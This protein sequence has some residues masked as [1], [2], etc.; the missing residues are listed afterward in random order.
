[1]LEVSA[2][3]LHFKGPATAKLPDWLGSTWRGAMGHALKQTECHCRVS[4]KTSQ[5]THEP[6]CIY[7]LLFETPVPA[8]ATRLRKYPSAPHPYVLR[9][10]KR[11]EQHPDQLR[12]DVLVFG[13]ARKYSRKLLDA[14]RTSA[15]NGLG[16][17]RARFTVDSID[18]IGSEVEPNSILKH[19]QSGL[20][21]VPQ[22]KLTFLSPQLVRHRGQIMNCERFDMTGW[23]TN[24]L[25]RFNSMRYFHGDGIEPSDDDIRKMLDAFEKVEVLKQNIHWQQTARHSS[26]QKKVIDQSGLVGSLVID[27]GEACPKILPLLVSGT[28]THV[29]KST[30]MGQGQF[31]LELISC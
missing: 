26:R 14:I 6:D 13:R 2:F 11:N 30:V 17:S 10:Y 27:L 19:L 22:V 25:R 9:P 31:S 23:L 1:M 5:L 18:D 16:Q 12:L 7:S 28:Y 15:K 3:R 4:P 24:L 21:Q 20:S 8:G 29:G